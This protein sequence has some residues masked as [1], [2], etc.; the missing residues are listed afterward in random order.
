MKVAESKRQEYLIGYYDTYEQRRFVNT[1]TFNSGQTLDS[2]LS[3]FLSHQASS[4]LIK[5]KLGYQQEQYEEMSCDHNSISGLSCSKFLRK[6]EP[7]GLGKRHGIKPVLSQDGAD[8]L[9]PNGFS[10]HNN[11]LNKMSAILHWNALQREL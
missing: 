10:V 4:M 1:T 7:H 5:Y 11:T 8:H 9:D 2:H 6:P 3:V